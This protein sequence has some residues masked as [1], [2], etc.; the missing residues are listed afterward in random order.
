MKRLI[1]ITLFLAAFGGVSQVI[2]DFSDPAAYAVSQGQEKK[3]KLEM[4][5]G[6]DSQ[7][8]KTS[9][10]IDTTG[11]SSNMQMSR[12]WPHFKKLSGDHMTL[13]LTVRY[14]EPAAFFHVALRL[15]DIQG[16]SFHFRSVRS[17]NPGPGV[18]VYYYEIDEK[19][20]SSSWGKKVN[21][22]FDHP[23]YY[24]GVAIDFNRK[25]PSGKITFEKLELI[26]AGNADTIAT[27]PVLNFQPGSDRY[28]V[29]GG[30]NI[31]T[32]TGLELIGNA[33]SVVV[34]PY[35][36]D[37][38]KERIE[39]APELLRLKLEVKKGSG[40]ASVNIMDSN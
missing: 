17:Y 22:K 35:S 5:A 16:E 10:N 40:K 12:I 7:S 31:P 36:W 19:G 24:N 20:F 25:V 28:W 29:T 21:K 32:D 39:T 33:A 30:Q 6:P 23:I 37:S 15:T 1:V 2:D 4:V 34:K 38:R 26:T 27:L 14:S 3:Q 11:K 18:R 9:F 13:A 8:P